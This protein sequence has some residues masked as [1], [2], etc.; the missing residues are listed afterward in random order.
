MAE[1]KEKVVKTEKTAKATAGM[2][3]VLRRPII[4][5]KSAKLAESN[6]MAFEIDAKATKKDVANAIKAIYNVA[7]EKINIVNVKGKVKTFRGKSKGT[8][9]TV[10]KAYIALPKDAKIEIATNA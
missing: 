10:K 3:D 9:K 8:Q 5:E 4:S 7:P 1:K 2:Y 6:G